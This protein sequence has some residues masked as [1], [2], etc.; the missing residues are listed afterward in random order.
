MRSWRRERMAFEGQCMR[1][2]LEGN[3]YNCA[4]YALSIF[5]HPK[6]CRVMEFFIVIGPMSTKLR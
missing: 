2:A 6:F 3:A 1:T 4:I 5:D